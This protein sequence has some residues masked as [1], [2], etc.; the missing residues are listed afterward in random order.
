MHAL[1]LAESDGSEVLGWKKSDRERKEHSL[2]H[3][4]IFLFGSPFANIISIY[5][6]SAYLTCMQKCRVL[7]QYAS[8][9]HFTLRPDE[10]A[11]SEQALQSVEKNLYNRKGG[12]FAHFC[13]PES[14]KK[15]DSQNH[16][17]MLLLFVAMMCS[18]VQIICLAWHPSCGLQMECC[19]QQISI[20][21]SCGLALNSLH[22]S[23]NGILLC[24]PT[25]NSIP[26]T[27]HYS[28]TWSQ[29]LA[30]GIH[31]WLLSFN[32]QTTMH[33]NFFFWADPAI[34]STNFNALFQSRLID[35][36]VCKT[37]YMYPG[38]RSQTTG[39]SL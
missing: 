19:Y 30:L 23:F 34:T 28:V 12:F 22:A 2:M 18:C 20:M 7:Y 38:K 4:K 25:V 36:I 6:A 31:E 24:L 10:I 32:C 35:L 39:N 29:P 27:W 14:E 9:Q 33:L 37:Q 13:D 3:G 5:S 8:Q 17:K 11:A 15:G 16:I 26:R 21:A 1:P